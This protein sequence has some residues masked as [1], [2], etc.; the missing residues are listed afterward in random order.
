[1]WIQ[2]TESGPVVKGEY[3][4]LLPKAD[5]DGIAVAGIHLPLVSAPRAT[6]FGWNPL[7]GVAGVQALCDHAAGMV[8]FAQTKSERTAASDTRPSIN[9]RYAGREDY[10]AAALRAAETLVHERLLLEEDVGGVVA[11]ADSIE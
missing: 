1:M 3:P 5:S 8:P 10:H 11:A 2:Q 7:T 9:E 4:V 6:Y